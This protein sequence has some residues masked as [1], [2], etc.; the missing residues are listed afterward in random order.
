MVALTDAQEIYMVLSKLHVGVPRGIVLEL[1]KLG[2]LSVNYCNS[3]HMT[4]M[5]G[6]SHV[7]PLLFLQC[8]VKKVLSIIRLI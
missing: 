6:G 8:F 3:L 5:S 2:L 4:F 1:S 7:K